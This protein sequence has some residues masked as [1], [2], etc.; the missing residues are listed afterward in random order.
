MKNLN[1]ENLVLYLILLL[2]STISMA[3]IGKAQAQGTEAECEGWKDRMLVYTEGEKALYPCSSA[4][5]TDMPRCKGI[6]DEAAALMAEFKKTPLA[7]EPC[8][9]LQSTL[10]DLNRYMD[11]FK[12]AYDSY[13]GVKSF[14]PRARS[15]RI[16]LPISPGSSKPAIGFMDSFVPPSHGLSSTK[17]RT[18]RM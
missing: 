12:T 15:I 7:A 3:G 2:G 5:D 17:K 1:I 6:Y 9:A 13:A 18:M 16:T 8:G 11:N 4:D 14:F 10:S